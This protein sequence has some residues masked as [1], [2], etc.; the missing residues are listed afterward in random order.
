M[1]I[2]LKDLNSYRN[3]KESQHLLR[4]ETCIESTT[5]KIIKIDINGC[6]WI[7][8]IY[9]TVENSIMFVHK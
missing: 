3:L 9:K 5:A 6:P 7:A 8:E 2:S 1:L 4:H